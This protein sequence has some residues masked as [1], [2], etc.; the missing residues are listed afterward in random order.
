MTGSNVSVGSASTRDLR[1]SAAVL[2]YG[3]NKGSAYATVHGI[4]GQGK[5]VRLDAGRPATRAACAHLARAL[6]EA[7]TLSGFTP[8]TLLYLGA[9]TIAWWCAPCRERVFFAAPDDPE[10]PGV[11]RRSAVVPHPGLVFGITASDWYV[12]AVRGSARPCP[13]TKLFRAPYFNVYK[14]GRICEGNVRLP[15]RMAAD[16]IA[17]YER[18]FFNSN[19]THPNDPRGLIKKHKGG[20]IGF[21]TDMLNGRYPH[22]FPER[23]LSPMSCTLAGF[24]KRLEKSNGRD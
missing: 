4:E 16:M 6:G 19:F 9:Q 3:D 18:A 14:S 24:I 2:V 11:G 5:A 13:D 20:A 12:T 7:A 22:A 8:P 23:V 21:W 15:E 10:R 17:G 1:L